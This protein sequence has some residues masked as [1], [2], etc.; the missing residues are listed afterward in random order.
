MDASSVTFSFFLVFSGAAVFAAIALWTR[1]PLL[2]AY[3]ALGALFGPSG[4]ALID[5]LQLLRD[6]AHFGIIFLLFLLGLDMQ[7]RA[8]LATMRQSTLVSLL[9]SLLFAGMGY[10]VA[11]AFGF[12]RTEA[13]VTGLA[14][15]FSSTIIGIKLLPTTVLHHRHTGELMVGVLLLQDM[16]AI[17]VL[18]LLSG[19]SSVGFDAL[20]ALRALLALPLLILAAAA[21]VRLVLVRLIARFDRFQEFVFL[22]AIGWCLGMAE[23]AHVLGLSAEIGAFVAGV[24]IASS[25][26]S[27]YIALSLKPLRDFFLILFFFSL[28]AGFDLAVLPGIWPSALLLSALVLGLKPPVFRFLLGRLSESPKLAWD[29][30]LRLGQNSEFSL[31]IAYMATT[32]GML[33]KEASHLIQATAIISFVVSSYLVVL[34]LPNPIAISDALRRD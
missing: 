14:M 20:A 9:S 26:I 23:L 25:P 7:P 22:L 1:Q 30:G 15:M 28:G 16:L 19:S 8:L 27:Q 6:F 10:A 17:L 24:S 5:D 29:V 18:V 21:M 13:L 31:L 2:I 32:A 4:L 11:A 33:G 3:I 34:R 12:T